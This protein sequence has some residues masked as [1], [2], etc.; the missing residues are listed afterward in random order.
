MHQSSLLS[1]SYRI[2]CQ[3]VVNTQLSKK[4]NVLWN[5]E[6]HNR[7]LCSEQVKANLYINGIFLRYI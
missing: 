5:N 4:L 2:F 7:F 3:L 1:Q 6:I